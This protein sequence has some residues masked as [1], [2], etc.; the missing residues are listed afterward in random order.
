MNI[1]VG[2]RKLCSNRNR[3]HSLY[4]TRIAYLLPMITKQINFIKNV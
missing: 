2:S 3:A 1:A 4:V